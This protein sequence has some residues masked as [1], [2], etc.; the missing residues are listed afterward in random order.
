MCLNER[1]PGRT[2]SIKKAD[3]LNTWGQQ[4]RTTERVKKRGEEAC[5][6][7][8]EQVEKVTPVMRERKVPATTKVKE[9]KRG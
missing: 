7:R 8:L 9:S 6:R 1:D 2:Q 5:T 3:N 4:S